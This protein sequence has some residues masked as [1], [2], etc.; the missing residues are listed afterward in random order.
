MKIRFTKTYSLRAD[1]IAEAHGKLLDLYETVDGFQ[2]EAGRKEDSE[3]SNNAAHRVNAAR[4]TL[5]D[6]LSRKQLYLP[7]TT[8]AKIRDL[9]LRVYGSHL[10]YTMLREYS[11]TE[12]GQEVRKWMAEKDEMQAYLSQLEDDLRDALGFVD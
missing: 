8:T 9:F 1:A 7:K 6:F 4:D 10:R 2:F 12:R 5:I 3:K 11:D